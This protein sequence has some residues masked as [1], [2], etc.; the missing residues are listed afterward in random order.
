MFSLSYYVQV[1]FKS[2]NL[3]SDQLSQI[4]SDPDSGLGNFY[5]QLMSTGIGDP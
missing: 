4:T 5:N 3:S 1:A 2:L